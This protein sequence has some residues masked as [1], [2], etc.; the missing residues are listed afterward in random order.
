MGW[1]P[2]ATP[3]STALAIRPPGRSTKADRAG[4]APLVDDHLRVAQP[5]DEEG[6]K[7]KRNAAA[8]QG[9]FCTNRPAKARQNNP[10]LPRQVFTTETRRRR[11]KTEECFAPGASSSSS[12]LCLTF[13]SCFTQCSPCL[14]GECHVPVEGLEECNQFSQKDLREPASSGSMPFW[15]FR[16]LRETLSGRVEMQ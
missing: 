8:R 5:S 3:R 4:K 2:I 12:L 1:A 16:G 11:T 13:P 15:Q 9:R 14:C 7:D 10:K 6:A